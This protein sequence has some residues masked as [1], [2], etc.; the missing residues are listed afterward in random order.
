MIL[1]VYQNAVLL[2]STEADSS[3]G[4]SNRPQWTRSTAAGTPYKCCCDE[5]TDHRHAPGEAEG[6]ESVCRGSTHQLERRLTCGLQNVVTGSCILGTIF[7]ASFILSSE[8]VQN[9]YASILSYVKSVI[10]YQ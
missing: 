4:G 7:T 1:L 10:L 3:G 5:E 9:C 2:S 6:A 8:V